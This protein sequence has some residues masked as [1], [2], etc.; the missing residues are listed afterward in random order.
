M[1]TENFFD[2]YQDF[3][4][5]SITGASPSRLNA[6]YEALIKSNKEIIE[7]SSVLDLASHDGRWSFAALMNN[8]SRVLGIDGREDLVKSSIETMK[9]YKIPAEKYSFIVGDITKELKNM[10]EGTIDVVFCF[11]IF[12][13]ITDHSALLGDIKKLKPKYLI[14]DTR[15]SA[16][17]IPAIRLRVEDS[18]KPGASIK[19]DSPVQ[20]VI[21]GIPSRSAV[22]FMLKKL[23]FSFTYFDWH[24]KDRQNWK[25]IHDYQNSQRVSIV[26]KNLD[27]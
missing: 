22:E 2:T 23:G 26:A 13:H 12:Y 20:N 7:N 11:G 15:I 17:K 27:A 14:L 18:Q 6:R 3:Y 16:F 21:V 4:K 24:G 9:K 8:A 25:G 1:E 10:T 19:G 5:T